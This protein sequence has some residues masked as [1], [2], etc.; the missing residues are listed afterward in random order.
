MKIK[1]NIAVIGVGKMGTTLIESLLKNQVINPSQIYGTTVQEVH[2]NRIKE[3]YQINSG[4]DNMAAVSQSDIIVLAVKPQMI[5]QILKQIS[6][7][8]SKEKFVISIAA[9]ISTSFI[10]EQLN[11]RNISVIR[12]MPNIASLVNEGMTVLCPGKFVERESNLN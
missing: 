3:K 12:A 7:A 6:T 1:Q 2:A 5:A 8:L 9:A 10:E 4:T 11:E